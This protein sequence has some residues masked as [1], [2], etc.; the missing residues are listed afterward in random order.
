MDNVTVLPWND[1]SVKGR[2]AVRLDSISK[3]GAGLFIL[4]LD[5]MPTGPG[6]LTEYWMSGPNWPNEGEIDILSG[7]S[8]HDYNTVALHTNEGCTMQVSD[9]IY[10]TGSWELQNNKPGANCWEN[11]PGI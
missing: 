7:T 3:Y 9:D 5:H 8:N 2:D 4:N 10:F 1:T 11:A 6:V